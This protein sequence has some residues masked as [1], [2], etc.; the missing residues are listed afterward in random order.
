M[1]CSAARRAERGPKPGR[2]PSSWISLSISGPATFD[3]IQNGSFMPGGNDRPAVRACIFSAAARSALPLASAKAAMIRSS[4]IS[5]SD[6]VISDGSMRTLLSSPLAVIVMLTIPPP[7]APSTSR[8]PSWS[9]ASCSFSCIACAFFI[10][11]MISMAGLSWY[12]KIVVDDRLGI[13]V[14]DVLVRR[15]AGGRRGRLSF[16]SAHVDD[17]G[18]LESLE[19]LA[20]QR[21]RCGAVRPLGFARL[22]RLAQGRRARARSERHHPA[23]AGPFLQALR[24]ALRDA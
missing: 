24:Q 12:L 20:H 3:D 22:S 9:C 18:A 10:I 16:G 5:L 4:T 21:M 13:G 7:E 2:R 6:G 8:R 14:A 15:G 23:L 11:P 17:A 1:R 19:R